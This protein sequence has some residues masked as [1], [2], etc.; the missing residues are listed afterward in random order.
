MISFLLIFTISRSTV[1]VKV[2]G[3]KYEFTNFPHPVPYQ[4]GEGGSY[5]EN[6]GTVSF[7]D[8]GSFL[9]WLVGNKISD[10]NT[11]QSIISKSRYSIKY[12]TISNTVE[13]SVFDYAT[14][15]KKSPS[16]NWD[17]QFWRTITQKTSVLKISKNQNQII[18]KYS[19]N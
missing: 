15:W 2:D 19:I 5:L 12:Q 3:V 7:N 9:N 6:Q 4:L 17:S 1:S 13:M 18:I 14:F 10:H 8:E 16:K 11:A